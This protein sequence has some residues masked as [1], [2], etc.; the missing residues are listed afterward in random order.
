[1]GECSIA[2]WASYAD[3]VALRVISKAESKYLSSKNIMTTTLIIANHKNIKP[4]NSSRERRGDITLRGFNIEN[5]FECACFGNTFYP[6][7]EKLKNVSYINF[8]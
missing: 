6:Y 8:T 1:M 3:E 4:C 7:E 5:G 2:Y